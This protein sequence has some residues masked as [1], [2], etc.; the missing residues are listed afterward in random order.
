[1]E[2]KE[3]VNYGLP[4]VLLAAFL[5]GTWKTTIWA[6]ENVVKPILAAHLSLIETLQTS[7]PEHDRQLKT[8]AAAAASVAVK[9]GEQLDKIQRTLESQTGILAKA[10][11][12]QTQ[13]IEGSKA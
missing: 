5:W 3:L 13:V 10:I 11:N 1:M 8:V 12:Y 2:W 9:N 6:R 7:L 4:T